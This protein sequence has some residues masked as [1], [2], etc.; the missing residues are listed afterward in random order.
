MTAPDDQQPA[1]AAEIAAQLA[2]VSDYVRGCEA[3]VIKGELMDLSGLDRAVIALCEGI[4]RLPVSD[5]RALEDRMQKLIGG[6]D[7]LA[8]RMKEQQEMLQG[9]GT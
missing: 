7:S 1:G 4:A 9:G 5:A 2:S 3:R 8:L 6:L